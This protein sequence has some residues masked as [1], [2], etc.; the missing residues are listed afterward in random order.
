VKSLLFAAAVLLGCTYLNASE[1]IAPPRVGVIEN[2]YDHVEK[3]LQKMKIPHT[4]IKYRDI[5]NENMYQSYDALFFPCGA[6]MQLNTSI[7]VLARGSQ[8]RSMSLSEQYYKVDMKKTGEYISAYIKNGGAAYF[9]DWSFK[10]LQSGFNSFSFFRSFEYLGYPGQYKVKVQGELSSYILSPVIPL[11]FSHPGWTVPSEIKSAEILLS[12]DVDIPNLGMKHA[13]IAALIREKKGIA[14]FSSYHDATDQFG[15]MRY[16]ILRTIYKREVDELSQTVSRWGQSLRTIV[17]DKVLAGEI[18][19][20]FAVK[21]KEGT[22]TVYFKATE[23]LWQIDIFDNAGQLLYSNENTGSDFTCSFESEN[24][25]PG[26]VKIISLDKEKGKVFTVAS[27]SGF[28]LFPYWLHTCIFLL[29][30]G[31]IAAYLVFFRQNRWK[32]R[33]RF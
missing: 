13:P 6:E 18:A 29:G 11:T 23:G 33:M 7:N 32:G 12:T 10:F 25:E 14:L 17:V 2:Q 30:V 16:L 21:R 22:N 9:T 19:H 4:M 3:L 31:L 5:E 27:A 1:P 24:N 26:F 15:L 28:R 20:T 8:I